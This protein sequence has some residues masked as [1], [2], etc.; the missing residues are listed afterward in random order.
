MSNDRE[1]SA[2]NI[3]APYK[4][5]ATMIA[6][7]SVDVDN[8]SDVTDLTTV[9]GKLNEGEFITLANDSSATVYIA[10]GAS[11]GTIAVSANGSGVTQSFP[12]FSNAYR[13]FVIQ[14][15]RTFLHYIMASGT[16][17][18]T[19]YRSSTLRN[20]TPSFSFPAP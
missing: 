14:E 3:V 9:F 13:D 7:W 2:A 16:G 6:I 10:L 15:S 19:L 18:I 4:N 20:Q 5:T 1:Y 11:A 17:R 12:I 8:A